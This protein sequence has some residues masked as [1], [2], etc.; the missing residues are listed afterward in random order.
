MVNQFLLQKLLGWP[1]NII[2]IDY[3][4]VYP[5]SSTVFIAAKKLEAIIN[6]YRKSGSLTQ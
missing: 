5:F 2:F 4:K 1:I 3:E 6:Q